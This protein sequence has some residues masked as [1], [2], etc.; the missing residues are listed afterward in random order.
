MKNEQ[1][2]EERIR[3]DLKL[4]GN[5]LSPSDELYSKIINDVT[6]TKK[7]N[8]NMFKNKILNIGGKRLTTGILCAFMI[9]SI[10][11]F[12]TS[13]NLKAFA[14]EAIN[15][16]KTIFVLDETN[17]VVEKDADTTF[18]YP[19]TSKDTILSDNQLTK[20]NGFKVFFP[21]SLCS[22]MNLTDKF[23]S[24]HL[25]KMTY[26]DG[27]KLQPDI[28]KAIDDEDVFNSLTS[29]EPTRG[30]GAQYINDK[31]QL[32]ISIAPVSAE[33]KNLLSSSTSKKV[34]LNG[35]LGYWHEVQFPSYPLIEK[36]DLTQQDMSKKPTDIKTAHMFYWCSNG[37]FY[38]IT[39]L[40]DNELSMNE[41]AAIAK[42]FIDQSTKK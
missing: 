40:S 16:I 18:I 8:F 41:T 14:T 34:D 30:V 38:S 28:L 23:E 3:I 24:I 33:I 7:G 15:H 10:V 9:I 39:F 42:S 11:S 27:Q 13:N 2:F 4:K 37:V 21:K 17:K 20:K 36:N 12:S 1:D 32:F 35:T 22:D 29:Y 31:N 5:E 25:N 26:E 6:N 19:S